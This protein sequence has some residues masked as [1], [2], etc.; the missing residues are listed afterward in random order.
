MFIR[1][2]LLTFIMRERISKDLS[3]HRSEN[4][5]L[6]LGVATGQVQL[7]LSYKVRATRNGQEGHSLMQTAY[8]HDSDF[9][10]LAA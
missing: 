7:V 2:L 3:Y 9:P 6:G 1:V 8:K 4:P 5:G 10:L